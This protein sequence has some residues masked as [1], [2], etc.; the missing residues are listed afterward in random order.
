MHKLAV[1]LSW[2]PARIGRL[3]LAQLLLVALERCPSDPKPITSFDAYLA[4]DADL[5]TREES[6]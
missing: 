6:W 3:T 2:D 4:A 1:E 5:K